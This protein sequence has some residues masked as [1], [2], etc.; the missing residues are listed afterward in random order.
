[1]KPES[2]VCN[3]I[4]AEMIFTKINDMLRTKRKDILTSVSLSSLEIEDYAQIIEVL[5]T[6]EST[7]LSLGNVNR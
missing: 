7:A 4:E 5:T 6:R 1:V 2:V 3:W